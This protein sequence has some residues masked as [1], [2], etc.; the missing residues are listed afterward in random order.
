M[1]KKTF[2]KK[3]KKIMDKYVFTQ[4]VTAEEALDMMGELLINYDGKDRYK[5]DATKEVPKDLITVKALQCKEC[6]FLVEP[7]RVKGRGIDAYACPNCTHI[8]VK[9]E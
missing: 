2:I 8:L 9:V 6:G 4:N 1:K 3:T 5:I 7:V